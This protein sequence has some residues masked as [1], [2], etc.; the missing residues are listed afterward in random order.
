MLPILPGFRVMLPEDLLWVLDLEKGDQLAYETRMIVAEY[1]PWELRAPPE[2]LCLIAL[3]PGG[4]LALPD[5]LRIPSALKPNAQVRL[6]VFWGDGVRLEI[7]PW[8]G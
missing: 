6:R 7:R 4:L 1:V 2:G 8:A 3:G 5:A